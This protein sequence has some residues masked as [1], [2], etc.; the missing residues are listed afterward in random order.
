MAESN[1]TV[2]VSGQHKRPVL[3]SNDINVNGH[4]RRPVLMNDDINVTGH[5]K[6]PVLMNDDIRMIGQHKRPVLMLYRK[7]AEAFT[8]QFVPCSRKPLSFSS[9]L[10]SSSKNAASTGN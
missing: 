1:G 4:H 7:Q 6:R 3:M 5:H 8:L 9:G 2:N 10:F